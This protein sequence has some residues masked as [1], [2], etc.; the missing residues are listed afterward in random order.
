MS[1]NDIMTADTYIHAWSQLQSQCLQELDS[2]DNK[3]K[4]LSCAGN[5][6]HFC[7]VRNLYDATLI[8]KFLFLAS[9]VFLDRFLS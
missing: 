2:H 9:G 4:V 7:M 5:D 3:A 8:S 6:L 1:Y